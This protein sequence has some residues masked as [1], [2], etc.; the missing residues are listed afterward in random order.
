MTKRLKFW[1][2][3]G[4]IFL[5][6][7]LSGMRSQ[8]R[9]D[10]FDYWLVTSHHPHVL[11]A[12]EARYHYDRDEGRLKVVRKEKGQAIDAALAK[13]LRKVDPNE[14]KQ[15]E[16][17]ERSDLRADPLIKKLIQAVSR[18]SYQNWVEYLV[19]FENRGVQGL[20]K[21]AD[22]GNAGAVAWIREGFEKLGYATELHCYRTRQQGKECNVVAE[23]NGLTKPN[24]K[25]VVIGHLDDVGHHQ[26]GADDNATGA[27]ALL[28]MARVLSSY[29][30]ERS[31]VFLAS[32]G[33][34][35]GLMGS[36]AFVADKS[37]NG[38]LAEL[39][40]AI[41]MDMIGY[42]KDGILDVETNK[43][44][45]SEAKWYTDQVRLY[46]SLKPQITMPAWGSDHVP[47]LNK[48]VP[49]VL[50]IE[51]WDAKTPC[52][53]LACDQLNTIN[54]GYALEVVRLNLAVVAQKAEVRL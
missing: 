43:A 28:E 34:E 14:I 54:W 15:Y 18:M 25:V 19:T 37:K 21:K 39:K 22:S 45:E 17:S 10:R 38:K 33:E 3:V 53:H 12:V 23:K 27:V 48:G 41:N 1:G 4:A 51:H 29:D 49:A 36:T 32:N 11:E 7:G 2:P 8:A 20:D 44:F 46:T 9:S 16:P 5:V 35:Q 26:A 40:F 31:I 50:T 24:E 52:Y 13:Y 30:S 42:N 47:F 6:L